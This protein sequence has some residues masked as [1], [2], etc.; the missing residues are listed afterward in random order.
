MKKLL[1]ILCLSLTFS[2]SYQNQIV[3]FDL[4][5]NDE[6]SNIGNNT[7]IDLMVFDNRFNDKILGT[8]ELGQDEKISITNHEN[9]ALLLTKKISHNLEQKGFKK[10]VNKTIELHIEK[11]NYLAKREFFVGSS[12]GTAEIKVVVKNNKDKSI[13]TKNFN[14]TVANKHFVVPLAST[15]SKIINS[16]LQEI[17]SD[18]LN[19]AE[20]LNVLA[21]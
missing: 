10:G 6:K 16:M 17:I 5:F 1:S 9:V 7:A 20:L 14:I 15:D 4:N 2:C 18:I 11:L 12:E 13:F 8:K 3:K 19:N 21:N